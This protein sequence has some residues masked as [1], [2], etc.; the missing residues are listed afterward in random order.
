MIIKQSDGKAS[1]ML[2]FWGIWSTP[3]LPLLSGPPW[4]GVTAPDRVLSM[5]QKE[6]FDILNCVQ[7]ND[8]C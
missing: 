2:E 3:S 7:T 1:V 8:F 5:D 4:L 6:L